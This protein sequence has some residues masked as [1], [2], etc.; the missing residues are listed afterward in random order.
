MLSKRFFFN[1]WSTTSCCSFPRVPRDHFRFSW[2]NYKMGLFLQLCW[3]S[4]WW[5]GAFREANPYHSLGST[6]GPWLYSYCQTVL[7]SKHLRLWPLDIL[8]TTATRTRVKHQRKPWSV[9]DLS[10]S[11]IGLECDKFWKV[12]EVGLVRAEGIWMK[13]WQHL[14]SDTLSWLYSN[15]LTSHLSLICLVTNLRRMLVDNSKK[16]EDYNRRVN[17]LTYSPY[18]ETGP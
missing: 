17:G 4:D 16:E 12:L 5:A 8:K 13:H 11:T 14:L 1:Q 2:E 9:Y 6:S 7:S 3:L 18:T 10:L 15:P